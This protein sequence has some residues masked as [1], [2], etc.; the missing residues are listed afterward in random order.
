MTMMRF[1]LTLFTALYVA[2]G[3]MVSAEPGWR[4]KDKEVAKLMGSIKKDVEYFTKAVDSQYRKAT[5]R[6]EMGDVDIAA[7]LK[8]L[9][10]LAK[11]MEDRFNPENPANPEVLAFLRYAEPIRARHSRG[12]TLFGA[13]K[14]WPRLSGDIV[15]LSVEYNIRWGS[16]P[17]SWN[18]RRLN[19]KE[20]QSVLDSLRRS[21][22]YFRK[23]LDKAAKKA[24]VD[25]SARKKVLDAVKRM[26][27]V[28]NDVKKAAKKGNDA[29]GALSL[30]TSSFEES[31]RFVSREGLAI[32]VASSWG[33]LKRNWELV[34]AAFHLDEF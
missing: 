6:N 24:D 8:N 12:D 18:P 9:K 29:S 27:R 21:V 15:R 14:E 4:M 31:K 5:I 17:G 25:G 20:L 28:I 10:D 26:E 32:S 11:K 13:A 34:R 33:D 23:D 22:G 2:A 3:G 16:D 30:I 1:F 7:Y 19:D